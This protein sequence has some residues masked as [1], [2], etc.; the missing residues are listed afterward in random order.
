MMTKT[1][2]IKLAIEHKLFN[3]LNKQA[4]QVTLNTLLQDREITINNGEFYLT[5][6][7]VNTLDVEEFA[8]LFDELF[9]FKRLGIRGKSGDKSKIKKDA[10]RFQLETGLTFLEILDLAKRY[11]ASIN[12]HRYSCKSK[13]FFYKNSPRRVE[14]SYA[15][16]FMEAEEDE[17]SE[18]NIFDINE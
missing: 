8:R 1:M 2:M 5:N 6:N 17:V 14:H 11:L 15:K 3:L 18:Q 16:A 9:S 7:V 10:I 13:Y 4:C 12:D